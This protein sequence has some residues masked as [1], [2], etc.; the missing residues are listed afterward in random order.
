MS[1]EKVTFV[2]PELNQSKQ[3]LLQY[4]YN[5]PDVSKLNQ[6]AIAAVPGN[7]VSQISDSQVQDEKGHVPVSVKFEP[8]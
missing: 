3:H 7:A 1:V 5:D 4:G 2:Q 8:A 6:Q